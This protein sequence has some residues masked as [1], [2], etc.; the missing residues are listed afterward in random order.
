[1]ELDFRINGIQTIRLT[2]IFM[3]DG[4]SADYP[5]AASMVY[6]DIDWQQTVQVTALSATTI[7]SRDIYTGSSWLAQINNG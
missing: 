3:V 6:G 5:M 1:M 7:N 2:Y 4:T